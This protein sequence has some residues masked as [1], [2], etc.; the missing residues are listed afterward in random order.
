VIKLFLSSLIQI[1]RYGVRP[2]LSPSCRFYPSCSAY[3]LEAIET[4]GALTG[5]YLTFRRVCRC[6]PFS[7]GGVDPVPQ[8]ISTEKN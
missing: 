3:G 8:K 6:Q 7:L 1:Y 4:H 2:F 5:S